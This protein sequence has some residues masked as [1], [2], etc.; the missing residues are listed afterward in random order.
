MPC[1]ESTSFS[2]KK[3]E[4]KGL[5]R[6]WAPR[7]SKRCDCGVHLGCKQPVCINDNG[8]AKSFP[9]V[10]RAM[11]YLAPRKRLNVITVGLGNCKP[12]YS[13]NW[14]ST[15]YDNRSGCPFFRRKI[16]RLSRRVDVSFLSACLYTEWFDLDEPCSKGEVESVYVT[17]VFASRLGKYVSGPC[18]VEPPPARRANLA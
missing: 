7:L 15:V 9:N 11:R 10:C 5:D 4:G 16:L 6:R 18:S 12:L 1:H 8:R 17:N 14:R 2:S 13:G 3:V